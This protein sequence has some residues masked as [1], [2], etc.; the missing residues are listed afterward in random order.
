MISTQK[1]DW[2][3]TYLYSGVGKDTTSY[4]S[5]LFSVLERLFPTPSR[6]FPDTDHETR[7]TTVGQLGKQQ[8]RK[9]E[10]ERP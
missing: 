5:S 7:V 4:V 2:R 1:G 3:I 9:S 8:S 6:T 10:S